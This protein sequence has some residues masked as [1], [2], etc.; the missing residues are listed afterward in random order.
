M[1]D[2]AIENHGELVPT[3]AARPVLRG[4]RTLMLREDSLTPRGR[5]G[6]GAPSAPRGPVAAPDSPAY[7]ALR[8]WRKG[9]AQAQAV[10][11]YVIFHD[12]TLAEIAARRPASLDALGEIPGVGRT[13]LDRYGAE[14]LR[15]LANCD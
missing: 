7:A 11:A 4:E 3:E 8:D 1:L 12:R 13:K 9:Q 15:V 10:P 2:V 14:V 5:P 6:R